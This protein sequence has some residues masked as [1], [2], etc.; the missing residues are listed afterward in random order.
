VHTGID[1]LAQDLLG[2]LDGQCGDLLAQG[3]AGLHG[4]LLGFDTGSG[5]D[6][7]ALFRGAGLGFFDDGL[8]AALGIGQAGC[9]V[10]LRDLASSASTRWLAADSSDLAL[11]AAA[12]PSAIL[13][14][15]SSSAAAI[16]RPHEF[17]REP[18]QDQEHDH[19]NDQGTGDAHF[20][21]LHPV[22]TRPGA[23]E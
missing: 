18:D 11:S 20:F 22:A 17:H 5:N 19:L 9:A 15:R 1:F 16:G 4:L 2:A 21:I 23:R 3:F 12:R 13:L 7:V 14:A 10:S 8:R 6:L